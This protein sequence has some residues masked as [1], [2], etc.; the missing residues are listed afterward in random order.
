[1]RWLTLVIL[2]SVLFSFYVKI[3]QRLHLCLW[4]GGKEGESEFG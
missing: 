3:L 2:S 4:E 1:M